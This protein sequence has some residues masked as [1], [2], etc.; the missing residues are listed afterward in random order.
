MDI[1]VRIILD[2]RTVFWAG[3]SN[4]CIT[5]SVC[6]DGCLE[7]VPGDLVLLLLQEEL[8]AVQVGEGLEVGGGE[9]GHAPR[10]QQPVLRGREQGL[11]TPKYTQ[12]TYI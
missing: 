5:W 2:I 9:G 12:S 6:V 7:D 11:H 3:P 4:R 10:E 8:E 1:L